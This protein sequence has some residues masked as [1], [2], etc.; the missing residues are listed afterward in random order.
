MN[1]KK[2]SKFQFHFPGLQVPCLMLKNEKKS[3]QVEIGDNPIYP[4]FNPDGQDQE[5][6]FGGKM[7]K[8]LQLFNFAIMCALQKWSK[9][10]KIDTCSA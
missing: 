5:G 6:F 7:V 8:F 10:D 2:L 1:G 9:I 3:V 4:I